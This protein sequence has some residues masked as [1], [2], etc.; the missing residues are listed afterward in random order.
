MRL[1]SL[2]GDLGENLLRC[3]V[4]WILQGAREADAPGAN[5]LLET[6]RADE[7]LERVDLLRRACQLEDDR[8][9]ADVRD[10]C[11]E[12]LAER[13]QLGPRALRRRDLEQG[14][15]TLE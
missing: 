8:V 9:R 14:E 12:D 15:L 11:V 10:A 1:S 2:V 13:H 7:L 5:E 3:S 4:L 6:V